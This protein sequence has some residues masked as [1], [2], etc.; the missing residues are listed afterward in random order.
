MHLVYVFFDFTSW[1]IHLFN[2]IFS[3]YLHTVGFYPYLL[4]YCLF[5]K[6]IYQI[7]SSITLT[8]MIPNDLYICKLICCVF[9]NKR[10]VLSCFFE[11]S[12]I[13]K[14]FSSC[15]TRSDDFWIL[16]A[17]C[18][19]MY[20][21]VVY[22]S[23]APVI[24]ASTHRYVNYFISKSWWWL[25]NQ[26]VNVDFTSWYI[27]L[28]DYIFSCYLHTVGFYPYLLSYCLF[29]KN[30]YQI[31]SYITLTWM[32]SVRNMKKNKGIVGW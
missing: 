5:G 6:N 11:K 29:R 17:M 18:M 26:N 1:Y 8:W 27:H 19:F 9:R 23:F 22:F 25:I 10:E 24:S 21:F 20:L 13:F 3:C 7:H 31:Y 15:Q 30:I 4:S 14:Y 12:N 16:N 2:Y 32:I 28:F